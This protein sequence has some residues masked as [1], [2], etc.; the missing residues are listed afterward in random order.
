MGKTKK[1][2]VTKHR[3]QVNAGGDKRAERQARKDASNKRRY[4]KACNYHSREE[5]DFTLMLEGLGMQVKIMLG[6]CRRRA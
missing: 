2:V 5:Q 1:H 3:G 4:G 6:E